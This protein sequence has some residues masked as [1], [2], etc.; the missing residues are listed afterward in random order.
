V[1]EQELGSSPVELQPERSQLVVIKGILVI[2]HNAK[3]SKYPYV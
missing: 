2:S 3:L 1:E